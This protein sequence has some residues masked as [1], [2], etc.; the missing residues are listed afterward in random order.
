MTTTLELEKIT[1]PEIASLTDAEI[2][3]YLRRS[4]TIAEIVAKAERETLILSLCEQ[5][6]ITIS[7]E[8]WQAGGDEFRLENKLLGVAETQAWLD[9]QRIT[10]DDWSQG[11]KVSLLEKKLKE[12]LFGLVVDSHYIT[13][14][15]SYRRVA[16]SQIL[17]TDLTDALKIAR[18]IRE[19]QA[20]FCALALE[21]SKGKQSQA[22]GGFAGIRF[23]IE[24]IPE[25]AQAIDDAQEGEVTGPIHT[26]LGYHV[27]R[28]EKWF[29]PEL[30]ETVRQ[31]IL[32][33]LFQ[34]WL[35]EH[36]NSQQLTEL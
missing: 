13:N 26:K 2:V 14:R 4:C 30:N 25:I 34:A 18:A 9:K 31:Q 32:E 6:E 21:R 17:V 28:V 27:L 23:V 10:V 35:K 33:T 29:L 16:L 22:N 3:A 7:D 12:H 1:L 11:I 20:S 19:E 15:D 5:L 8:E 36:S 24:L